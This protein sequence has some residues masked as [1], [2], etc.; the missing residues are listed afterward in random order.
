MKTDYYELLGVSETATLAELKKG[1]RKRALKLHPDKNPSADAATLFNEIRT[2]YE[3]LT[4]PQE[5]SWYDSHKYQILAEDDDLNG[6]ESNG[7]DDTNQYYDGTTVED[8]KRYFNNSLYNRLDDSVQGF[9]QVVNVLTTKL[10]SE[11]VSSGKRQGLPNFEKFKDDSV[12]SNACDPHLLLFPRF[13]NSKADYGTDVRL[14]YKIWGNFQSVKTFSWTDEYR[15]STAQDR[16]T[17][18]SMQRENKKVRTRA[19][20]DFNETVRRWISFIKKKDPRVNVKAQKEYEQFRIKKRQDALKRQAQ[21]QRRQ[22]KHET[23]EYV[24]QDW[25]EIDA[26]ELTEIEQELDKIYKEEERLRGQDPDDDQK[27]TNDIFE[28]IVCNKTF[29]SEQKFAEH[30]NSRRHKKR[31]K[32]LKWQMRKEGLE[33]GIDKKTFVKEEEI[34][35]EFQD[36]VENPDELPL[37]EDDDKLQGSNI[38]ETNFMI[39]P[40]DNVT[41]KESTEIE[42]ASNYSQGSEARD[43]TADEVS[44]H[45]SEESVRLSPDLPNSSKVAD[46]R[47]EDD[48]HIEKHEDKQLKELTAILKGVSLEAKVNNDEDDWSTNKRKKKGR[49]KVK[50]ANKSQRRFKNVPVPKSIENIEKCAVCGL[51][52]GSRNKLF[53][54]INNTNHAMPESKFKTRSKQI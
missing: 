34:V 40:L 14:F 13:G 32:K 41:N 9:Y 16:R 53:Q 24:E 36:A 29:K 30:E 12:Y 47:T 26:D 11:E 45:L 1:F 18:R 39:D 49:R 54:H 6:N 8:I 38:A 22:R 35:Q 20:K 15:Y 19:R 48:F 2:A 42:K 52:F 5:R 4:D 51:T 28:C 50:K 10:A 23:E 17:M 25:Q 44:L 37:G 31:L 46:S 43:N 3:T 27:E 21:T 33:L 7:D